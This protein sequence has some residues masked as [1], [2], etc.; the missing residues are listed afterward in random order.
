[1]RY[2]FLNNYFRQLFIGNQLFTLNYFRPGEP[3][4]KKSRDD[5]PEA[6]PPPEPVRRGR[7]DDE[8]DEKDEDLYNNANFDEVINYITIYLIYFS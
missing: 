2:I 4:A 3:G 7:R 5:E 8:K 1:M 6:P